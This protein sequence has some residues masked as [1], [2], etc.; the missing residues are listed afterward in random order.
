MAFVLSVLSFAYINYRR[1]MM[2]QRRLI[3]AIDFLAYFTFIT[4]YLGCHIVSIGL[5]SAE[6]ISDCFHVP[7][8]L[9]GR[10]RVVP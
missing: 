3:L 1:V 5:R 4:I 7:P 10:R 8:P 6:F 2:K 9:R